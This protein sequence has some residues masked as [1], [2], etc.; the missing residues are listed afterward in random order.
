MGE[1]WWRDIMVALFLLTVHDPMKTLLSV[2]RRRKNLLYADM[3][4]IFI[5]RILND[6]TTCVK[7]QRLEPD[8][9]HGIMP[10]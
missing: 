6:E 7:Q 9:V 2:L 5:Q 3:S 4:S 1:L 8:A 10:H